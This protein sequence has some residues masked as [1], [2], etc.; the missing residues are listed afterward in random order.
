MQYNIKFIDY[1]IESLMNNLLN[2]TKDGSPFSPFSSLLF[3]K[4]DMENKKI[5]MYDNKIICN[6]IKD[7]LTRL[8]H[9]Q[10]STTLVAVKFSDCYITN[11]IAMELA[12][13]IT[14]ITD[15]KLF[16]LS[17][18][19]IQESDLKVIITALKSTKSL[20]FFSIKFIDCF[21]ED[22]AEDIASII[23]RNKSIK[24]LEISNCD[25]KQS[26]ILK[27]AKSIKELR[28]LKQLNLSNI[29]LTCEALEFILKD[30]GVLEQLNLQHC[31]LLNPELTK[32][33]SALKHTK[34]DSI[35]LS[36][37]NISDY[38]AKALAYLL[39]NRSLNHLE[40]SNC[41][42]QEEGM[43][44]II[45]TLKYKSLKYLDFSGNRVTDFLATE[46][47]AGIS[48]N[49]NITHLD[50][51][52]CSLQEIGIV[53]ILTSL[54][55]HTSHLKF[56]K[57]SSLTSNEEIVRLFEGVLENNRGIENLTTQDCECE[58]I[59]D[60]IRGNLS[61]L[62]TLDVRSSKIS[63]Q[64]LMCIVANNINLRHL[65]MSNCDLQDE[66]DVVIE[67]SGFL[68][69][70][71][72]LSEN[73]ITKTF[74]KFI[75]NLIYNNYKLKQ[76]D[77]ANCEIQETE[78]NS[79]TNSLIL[80]TSL[81][82]L[83]CSNIIIS[84]KIA[85][86]IAKIITNN[87]NL[88]NF[89]ISLCCMT[90]EIFTPIINALKQLQ[91]LKHLN[92]SGNY[93]TIGRTG[94]V[95][96]NKVLLGSLSD[97]TD[98]NTD[99]YDTISIAGSDSELTTL[100]AKTSLDLE[101]YES[102]SDEG[103]LPNNDGYDTISIALGEIMPLCSSSIYE[104]P[105]LP[106]TDETLISHNDKSE[107]SIDYDTRHS[108]ITA[109]VITEASQ[110]HSEFTVLQTARE[111]LLSYNS[112]GANVDDIDNIISVY[113]EITGCY[114]FEHSASKGSSS[115]SS[116]DGCD[117]DTFTETTNISDIN[118][119]A[120][121]KLTN[122]RSSE[123]LLPGDNGYETIDDMTYN[124]SNERLENILV[125][126][127]E[128]LLSIDKS[129]TQ[130]SCDQNSLV[131]SY[132]LENESIVYEDT[133]ST[134]NKQIPKHLS[135]KISE[136]SPYHSSSQTN[137]SIAISKITEVIACNCFLE[138]LDISDCYLS[139]LHIATLAL[140][141][142]KIS[143]L[144]HLNLSYNE[145]TT[146]KTALKI[147]SIIIN[148]SL[149]KINLSNCYL[150]ESS[151]IIIAQALANITSLISIDISENNIAGNSTQSVAAVVRENLLEKLN[152]GRCFQYS[153]D[154][155]FTRN[156]QGVEY[157]LMPLTMLTCLKYLDL[158]SSYISE[159][160]SELLPVVVANNKSLSHLDL[161]D[162]KLPSMKVTAIATKL[163]STC[164]LKFLSL[165]S[166]VI[167][168]EA[169][170]ELAK[171]ISKNFVLE[172]LALSDCELE[173]RG[174]IDIAESFL[175]ISSM[176]HL[177]LSNNI[178]TDKAAKTLA[179]GITNNMKLTFLDLSYCT[180]QDVGFARIQEVVFKLPMVK[181]FDIRSL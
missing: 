36:Y 107:N 149:R 74:A 46:I 51:S 20:I 85:G 140:A 71:V 13:I 54:Q 181:E 91:T 89:D 172:N 136:N 128:N 93:I 177:N 131:G 23:V 147:S 174:F 12:S 163:Q 167:V 132:E 146:D 124:N 129:S 63:F 90:E 139:D 78:L 112:E 157:I 97:K 114:V 1:K 161:T 145:I 18:N 138:Y 173:E 69:E 134:D 64:N 83:N 105:I 111:T 175:N 55:E 118:I 102:I 81:T 76:V 61:C 108:I 117:Y 160:A 106:T 179:S 31:K 82:C 72:N 178:I 158:H 80:I 68:L 35:N 37:N 5:C 34:L 7:A 142:S 150:Q 50:L 79:I 180:W 42:L 126:D 21:I 162:C 127:Y 94:T 58:E 96:S 52:N 135:N 110:H 154:M 152:L 38:S 151:I 113:D 121:N 66:P 148:N 17:Y 32:I 159:V 169:A 115:S 29:A 45:N 41:N 15:L 104:D 86:N 100:Y 155:S 70:H 120:A 24:Y 125:D 14:K 56:L 116:T 164:T 109:G 143:T 168:N 26:A 60:A 27:I 75:T 33:S 8:I 156:K 2:A 101:H 44:C 30:K 43:L 98:A 92:I 77:I 99:D 40:M 22:T 170:Y 47:S 171:A 9:W 95:S 87:V 67:I 25:I 48:N 10:M 4:V 11:K 122:Y 6:S 88:E 153:T 53:E 62:Q 19:H 39:R 103:K 141:L 84:Q 73:K 16:E 123:S 57:N 65:N 59:F 119:L 165:S 49:P 176:K 28:E 133:L 130:F 3:I 144:K 166:N 137:V